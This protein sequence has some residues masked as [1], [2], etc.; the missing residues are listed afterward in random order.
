MS[1]QHAASRQPV[2]FRIDREVLDAAKTRA[3]E[4]TETMTAVVE[5]GLADYAGHQREG[6]R[7]NPMDLTNI[8][9]PQAM[10]RVV[11]EALAERAE[12]DHAR[13]VALGM[14]APARLAVVVA[15][16]VEAA[17]YW[18]VESSHGLDV[19]GYRELGDDAYR[20]I[21]E[22]IPGLI[23]SMMSPEQR[24]RERAQVIADMR[25]PDDDR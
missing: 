15:V 13:R 25:G 12:A 2:T 9:D 23:V 24:A 14:E 1:S 10:R 5:R 11:L 19:A 7:S 17:A 16:I 6:S 20:V 4:R 3:A 21:G 8:D 18:A 22:Q